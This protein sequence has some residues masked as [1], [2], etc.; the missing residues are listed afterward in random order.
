[1]AI[2][3]AERVRELAAQRLAPYREA[4]VPA[5]KDARVVRRHAGERPRH[6]VIGTVEVGAIGGRQH[7]A[8]PD[9]ELGHRLELRDAVE[10]ADFVVPAALGVQGGLEHLGVAAAEIEARALHREVVR[11]RGAV[12]CAEIAPRIARAQAETG[13]ERDV[14]VDLELGCACAQAAGERKTGRHCSLRVHELTP[15]VVG[16]LE[17]P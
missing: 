12:R 1:M 14:V 9:I 4:V 2:E 3:G 6:R 15:L 13:V 17:L 8:D 16:W 5:G 10:Q 11:L 7:A